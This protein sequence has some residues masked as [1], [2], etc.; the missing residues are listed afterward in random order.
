[1]K[2]KSPNIWY[3][4]RNL[5]VFANIKFTKVNKSVLDENDGSKI[6]ILYT[7][8]KIL[9]KFLHSSERNSISK[10]K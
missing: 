7:L 2:Y 6:K 4:I 5:R 1:M 10:S 9:A 3:K 8:E